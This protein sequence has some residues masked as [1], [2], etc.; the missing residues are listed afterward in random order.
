M[1]ILRA[2]VLSLPDLIIGWF[3][4]GFGVHGEFWWFYLRPGLLRDANPHFYRLNVGTEWL[5]VLLYLIMDDAFAIFNASHN[6]I[7]VIKL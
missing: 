3:I 2:Y 6:N 1:G 7:R 4:C 5:I